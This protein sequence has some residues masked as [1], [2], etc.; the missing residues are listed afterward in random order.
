MS[1]EDGR[2]PAKDM[3]DG[4]EETRK[5]SSRNEGGTWES[6]RAKGKDMVLLVIPHA[7]GKDKK[8]GNFHCRSVCNPDT[9]DR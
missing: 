7:M 6:L 8:Q 1:A 3:I 4:S 5:S 2:P 9:A